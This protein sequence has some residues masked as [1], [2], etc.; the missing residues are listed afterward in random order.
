MGKQNSSKRYTV[1]SYIN[2]EI[3][4][5]RILRNLHQVYLAGEKP[6]YLQRNV[7]DHRLRDSPLGPSQYYV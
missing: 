3:T 2:N 5:R 6:D 4:P 7:D 1:R